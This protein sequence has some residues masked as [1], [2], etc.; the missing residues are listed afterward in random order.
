VGQYERFCA[1]EEGYQPTARKKKKTTKNQ[2]HKLGSKTQKT[3]EKK[4]TY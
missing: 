4:R 2:C 3:D 1:Q